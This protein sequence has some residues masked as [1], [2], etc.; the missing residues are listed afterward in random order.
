MEEHF[1]LYLHNRLPK[2]K[3]PTNLTDLRP[4]CGQVSEHSSHS[5]ICWGFPGHTVVRNPPANAGGAGDSGLIPELG[6]CPGKGNVNSLRYSCPE[7]LMDRGAW[8]ATV[9]GVAKSQTQ[10]NY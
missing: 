8:R 2:V 6:R 7:N 1:F 4:P 3:F 9:H 5:A 10:L